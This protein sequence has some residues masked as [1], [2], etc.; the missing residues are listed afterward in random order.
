M[1]A[2]RVKISLL[3][4]VVAVVSALGAAQGRRAPRAPDYGHFTHA[5]HAGAVKVPGT[6]QTRELKCDSCHERRAAGARLSE[7]I[8]TPPRNEQLSLTF[9]GHKACAECHI[10]QF[11]SRPPETCSICHQSE[12]GLGARPPQRDFPARYDYNAFFDT[13]QHAEHIKYAFADGKQL[14]CDFCHQP[15]PKQAALMIPSH[16]ACY[17][18]H[19]PAS[20]DAKAA[21]RAGCAVCHTQTVARVEPHDYRSRAYGARFTHRTHVG[22]AGGNCQACHTI[23]GGYNQP[24]PRPET[25]RVKEHLAEG[26]RGGRGCFS[27]HD[28]GTH[29]GRQVFSGEYP[30]SGSAACDRCHRENFKVFA[31]GG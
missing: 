14:D 3:L 31:E 22:Y 11:T 17:A 12:A 28:G 30:P 13:R 21:L 20:G 7:L 18:C 25:I 6:S 29:Y 19:T 15:T 24:Q 1:S 10:A 26:Q 8:A 9:P 27:C 16:P 23:T 4:G 5:S 2:E